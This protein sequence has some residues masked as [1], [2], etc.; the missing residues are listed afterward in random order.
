[1]RVKRK[2]L[3]YLEVH[4]V[5]SRI[6]NSKRGPFGIL[7]NYKFAFNEIKLHLNKLLTNDIPKTNAN[8]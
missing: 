2:P 5:L 8:E 4:T 7:V 1:M 3:T 6:F